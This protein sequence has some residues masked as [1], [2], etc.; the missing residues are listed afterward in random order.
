MKSIAF[1]GA[2]AAIIPAYVN[3]QAQKWA[4]CGGIG[5]SMIFPF[6]KGRSALRWLMI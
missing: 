6:S 5:W 1:L 3:A 4:Q 2:L